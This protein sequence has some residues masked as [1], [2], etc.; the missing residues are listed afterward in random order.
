MLR[1]VLIVCALLVAGGVSI[2]TRNY[3][4]AQ[5]SRMGPAAE[6]VAMAEVL[7]VT[8]DL[9]IGQVVGER[10]AAW[11]K[12]PK[13]NLNAKYI[14][15]DA[16]PDAIRNL[17]GAAARQPLFAG[18]PV[19]SAKLVK[20]EGASILAIV[21]RDGYR[22]VT[23][24]V[25]EAQGLAG[26]VKPGDRVDVLLTHRVAIPADSEIR[27]ER[28]ISEVVAHAVRVLAVGQELKG[29]DDKGKLAKS[30]TI[31]VNPHQAE[32][33]TLG[34]SMGTLSLALRSAFT[35]DAVADDRS[36]SYT[37]DQD[38]SGALRERRDLPTK[39]LIARRAV[40]S[41][42]L[43]TDADL[44]WAEI[45]GKA[46]PELH[47]LKVSDGRSHLRGALLMSA[48]AAG[49]PILRSDLVRP[50]DNRF[51]PLALRP[52]HPRDQ[53]GDRAEHGR[54]RLR[55]AR[56]SG[57]RDFHRHGR[58]P[59]RRR[60]SE[61]AELERGGGDRRAGAVDREHDGPEDRSADG[62]RHRHDRSDAAT[63]R[64]DHAGRRHGQADAGV[65]SGV[66]GRERD[67]EDQAP[68]AAEAAAAAVHHRY[69]NEPRSAGSRDRHFFE[70]RPA[71]NGG[72]PGH[73]AQH[74]ADG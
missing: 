59:V 37:T 69:G 45:P 40:E 48:V 42:T 49:Q 14:T 8:T 32:A 25:D 70:C 73:G 53:R 68:R 13:A 33:I 27:G 12:W 72:D 5:E 15:R 26:L 66:R 11:Q 34:R 71:R 19:T 60:R 67:S 30:I 47:F 50:T 16:N 74:G 57:G 17:T 63:G 28:N 10:N 7:V 65:A 52:G 62:G 23:M 39:V 6:T 54:R 21:L 36:Q 56:R 1:I 61:A 29:E 58:R 3:L 2:L 44:T 9:E 31:E 51:I 18:E 35:E 55:H 43:L 64:N 4:T 41:G 46:D 22:A 24:K 20:R 38:I